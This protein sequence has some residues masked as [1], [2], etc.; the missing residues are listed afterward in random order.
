MKKR[1]LKHLG[2]SSD[3]TRNKSAKLKQE[4]TINK[5]DSQLSDG[6][7]KLSSEDKRYAGDDAHE[8]TAHK[9]VNSENTYSKFLSKYYLPDHKPLDNIFDAIKTGDV[10]AVQFFLKNGADVENRI[11]INTESF[12]G[13]TVTISLSAIMFAAYYGHENIFYYLYNELSKKYKEIHESRWFLSRAINSFLNTDTNQ[14]NKNFYNSATEI[15]TQTTKENFS[16]LPKRTI[17]SMEGGFNFLHAAILGKNINIIIA[18]IEK[19]KIS[20][21]TFFIICNEVN[22]FHRDIYGKSSPNEVLS[23]ITP[24]HLAVRTGRI[25]IVQYLL[26]NGAQYNISTSISSPVTEDYQYVIRSDSPLCEVAQTDDLAMAIFLLNQK[27]NIESDCWIGTT[28][29]TQALMHAKIDMTK[30]LIN[31]NANVNTASRCIQ[32]YKTNHKI[33]KGITP[34]H[35]LAFADNIRDRAAKIALLLKCG[36]N[37]NSKMVIYNYS[38]E[39]SFRCADLAIGTEDRSYLLELYRNSAH[40]NIMH[41]CKSMSDDRSNY[42]DEIDFVNQCTNKLELFNAASHGDINILRELLSGYRTVKSLHSTYDQKVYADISDTDEDGNTALHLACMHGQVKTAK[43]LLSKLANVDALND[44]NETPLIVGLRYCK[45]PLEI[46]RTLVTQSNVDIQDKKG[47]T[48]IM[49]AV[50]SFNN[51]KLSEDDKAAFKLLLNKVDDLELKDNDGYTVFLYTVKTNY[52]DGVDVLIS[53]NVNINVCTNNNENALMVLASNQVDD[54]YPLGKKLIQLGIPVNFINS[55]SESAFTISN[56]VNFCIMLIATRLLFL[57]ANKQLSMLHKNTLNY[58]F[59]VG[60]DINQRDTQ[61]RTLLHI[62]TSSKN[63]E[64]VR[65]L[66][67]VHDADENA[68]DLHDKTIADVIEEGYENIEYQFDDISKNSGALLDLAAAQ[69]RLPEVKKVIDI[70][71]PNLYLKWQSESSTS[72]DSTQHLNNCNKSKLQQQVAIKNTSAKDLTRDGLFATRKRNN[73][74]VK[75]NCSEIK[76]LRR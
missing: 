6:L 31:K 10:H 48:A 61:L 59:N 17:E 34:L 63:T 22:T 21:N 32:A 40:H 46:T 60:G 62:A 73:N 11:K 13:R 58:L 49:Y 76:L 66:I 14:F 44:D 53:K 67:E 19:L 45:N 15:F 64:F 74:T 18:T 54:I 55:N 1:K 52:S 50:T 30:L 3:L 29:L 37:P 16:E 47:K 56:N 28:A 23:L 51:S 65:Y 7:N 12:N 20:P 57:I 70:Y 4:P 5:T 35:A 8:N 42:S 26:E 36:A 72:Q 39:Y 69:K 25:D 9:S 24:L 43:F 38:D 75:N 2:I 33:I 27:I 68:Q 41:R 71:D